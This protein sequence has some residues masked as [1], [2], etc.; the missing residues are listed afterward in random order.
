MKIKVGLIGP[1]GFGNIHLA[2]YANNPNCKIIAL[3]SRTKSHSESAA[4]EFSVDK[5]YFGNDG[6]KKMLEKEEIDA[7]SICTPNYLHTPMALE[8]LNQGIHVLC[9]KP[10]STT[11]KE[12]EALEQATKQTDLIFFTSFQKR[13]NPIMPIIREILTNNILGKIIFINYY[14]SHYGPY[15]S[16]K[17]ISEEKWFFNS[18]M[19]GGGV[20]L[21]LGV[22]CIDILRYLI[23]DYQKINGV[24]ANTS[25]I[26]MEYEDN[27]NVLINFQNGILGEISVSWCNYPSE[28]IKIYGSKGN[29]TIDLHS[30]RPITCEPRTLKKNKLIKKALSEK[31]HLKNY[32]ARVID[33][34]INSIVE[35][36]QFHPNFEDGK[37]AVEFVLEAYSLLR[38]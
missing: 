9:E 29:L 7:I 32:Q 14:F 17:A 18:K 12:L 31:I 24:N 38:E 20:L 2:G 15:T 25:C 1:G 6:W 10:I 11:H 27:C 5:I 8:A 26:D 3:S 37:K 34:F 35:N 19:A 36:R 33:E 21:D 30:K 13:F 16:W 22:H 4:K 23:G 28:M